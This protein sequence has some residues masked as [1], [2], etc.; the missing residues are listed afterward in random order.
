[1]D[2]MGGET[3]VFGNRLAH[4]GSLRLKAGTRRDTKTDAPLH[5]T[6]CELFVTKTARIRLVGRHLIL[7]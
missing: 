7:M 3:T 5:L 2:A 1:M 6:K 4:K